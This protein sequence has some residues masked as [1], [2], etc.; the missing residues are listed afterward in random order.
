MQYLFPPSLTNLIN[1]LV[2]LP[3]IGPKSAQRLAF[4]LLRA[5]EEDAGGLARAILEARSKVRRCSVCGNLSDGET[6]AVCAD[7]SRDAEL[8]CVVE[9]ARDVISMERMRGFGGYYHVLHGAISPME[10]IG[11]ERLTIGPLME[12]LKE[13]RVKEVVMATN[14]NVE[15]ETTSLYLAK[16]IKPLGVRVTR[17]AHGVPVGGDLEYADE[18][19][20]A[21]AFSGRKEI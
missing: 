10:G 16:L 5:K 3:G 20:L 21:F 1:Q 12:R 8:L 19:T 4:H 13:G 11:P 7:E 2:R 18:A 15:G 17:I 9:E 14:P 6:C